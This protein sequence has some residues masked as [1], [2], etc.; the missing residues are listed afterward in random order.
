MTCP[1]NAEI[2]EQN[3]AAQNCAITRTLTRKGGHVLTKR[4]REDHGIHFER[5]RT[6]SN[7]GSWCLG[8]LNERLYEMTLCAIAIALAY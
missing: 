5:K 4:F 8:R 6:K 1:A 2:C 3:C 7:S